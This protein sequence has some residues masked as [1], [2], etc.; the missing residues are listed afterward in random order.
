MTTYNNAVHGFINFSSL[1][2]KDKKYLMKFLGRVQISSL[3]PKRLNFAILI[4]KHQFLKGSNFDQADP[5]FILFSNSTYV[6]I[7]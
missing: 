3:T 5:N 7:F 1:T 4:S 6:Q 2:K